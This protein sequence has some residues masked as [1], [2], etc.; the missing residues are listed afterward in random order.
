V[1]ADLVGSR[2]FP[3]LRTQSAG[4]EFEGPIELLLGAVRE[5]EFVQVEAPGREVVVVPASAPAEAVHRAVQL[6]TD[7]IPRA[8]GVPTDQV[9]V[10]VPAPQGEAG[11]VAL[12]KALKARLNDGP[13]KF[14]GFDPGDRVITVA[15]FVSAPLGE[16]GVVLSGTPDGLEI[17]FPSGPVTVPP[18]QVSRLRHGWAITI[19]QAAGTR[20]PAVVAVF[21]AEAAATLSRPLIATAIGRAHR[22]LSIVHAAGPDL[23]KAVA[24]E[25][26]K[27]RQTRLAALLRGA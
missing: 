20:W 25:P 11:A 12:N 23:A 3:T 17:E 21:T 8:I 5:G 14:G 4:P 22:H 2:A 10:V 1:F 9:Q 19:H 13:G 15:A 7:S 18:S 27:P 26:G 24:D 6:V 16:T